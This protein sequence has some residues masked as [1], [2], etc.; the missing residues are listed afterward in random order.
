LCFSIPPSS[1]EGK[2]L[3][4]TAI[5]YLFAVHIHVAYRSRNPDS[6]TVQEV[7]D[8]LQNNSNTNTYKL[9]YWS[10]D[11]CPQKEYSTEGGSTAIV[12]IL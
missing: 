12:D 7:M 11:N 4:L 3:H 10:A 5:D 8:I 1:L 6:E 2:I 9:Q